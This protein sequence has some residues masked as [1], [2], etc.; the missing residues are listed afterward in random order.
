MQL[1][2]IAL[3]MS[4]FLS[5]SSQAA[6]ISTSIPELIGEY[7]YRNDSR[8]ASF[9]LGVSFSSITSASIELTALGING[10]AEVCN[11]IVTGL[12]TSTYSCNYYQ[13]SA[14]AFYRV[15]TENS[16]EAGILAVK[17]VGAKPVGG[18]RDITPGITSNVL[19]DTDQLLDGKGILLFDQARLDFHSYLQIDPTLFVDD[20]SIVIDGV[21]AS[22][23]PV[24]GA[25]WLFGSGLIGLVGVKGKSLKSIILSA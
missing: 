20:V 4:I 3:M 16:T 22:A 25:I 8:T 21:V 15:S 17:P 6:I 24:P 19:T 5:A 11:T 12:F 9:D 14:K 23:V 1:K 2:L 13:E 10:N 7:E 18:E